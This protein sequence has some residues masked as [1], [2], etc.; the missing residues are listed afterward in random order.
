MDGCYHC[1]VT[2]NTFRQYLT[3]VIF[4]QNSAGNTI[5]NNTIKIYAQGASW[6]DN[7]PWPGPNYDPMNRDT[8][9]GIIHLGAS[10]D[11]NV[12]AHNNIDAVAMPANSVICRNDPSTGRNKWAYNMAN[13]QG[14]DRVFALAGGSNIVVHYNCRAGEVQNIGGTSSILTDP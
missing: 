12:V 10:T 4:V 2:S 8:Q 3:G 13:H 5:A 11:H 1:V 14:S 9:Y 6:T 7:K